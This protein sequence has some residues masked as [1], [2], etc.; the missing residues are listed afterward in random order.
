[1]DINSNPTPSIEFTLLIRTVPLI[2]DSISYFIAF[3][4]R[5]RLAVNKWLHIQLFMVNFSYKLGNEKQFVK[6]QAQTNMTRACE[7]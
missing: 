5:D 1:M 2:P 6:E 4:S 7:E 3:N